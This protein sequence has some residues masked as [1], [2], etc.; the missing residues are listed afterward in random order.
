MKQ[1]FLLMA[2]ILIS[3]MVSAQTTPMEYLNAVPKI[4]MNP[5]A[6]DIG[7]KQQ[8]LDVMKNFMDAM[9]EKAEKESD[10]SEEFREQHQDEETISVL[11]KAG[12]TR[13]EAEKMKNL[14]NMSEEEKMKLANQWM[15]RNY[16]MTISETQKVGDMDSA[17]QQRWAKATSTMMMADAQLEP[18]KNT[19]KQLEIKDRLKLQDEV[20]YLH[21]KLIAGENKYQDMLARLD[22]EADSLKREMNPEIEKLYKDLTEGNGKP[23]PIIDRIVN[24]RQTYCDKFTPRYLDIIEAYKGYI[25][26]HMQEYNRLEDLQLK[27]AESQGILKDPNY[28]PGKLAMG[29]VGGYASMVAGIFKYNLNAVA[30]AQFVG[31]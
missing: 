23:K 28:K 18:D 4:S 24:L 7:E 15:E 9:D 16:N 22:A 19:A 21:D 10:A 29:R 17:A 26:D 27:L 12:Y 6:V 30:G 13:Q 2:A 31:Y 3:G 14:D 1:I 25:T 20:K 5:C 8:F 11:M